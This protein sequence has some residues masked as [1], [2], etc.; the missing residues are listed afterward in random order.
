MRGATLLRISLRLFSL[1]ACLILCFLLLI[2]CNELC[3]LSVP[4]HVHRS[5]RAVTV[6]GDDDLGNVAFLVARLGIV[7][8]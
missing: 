2:K 7:Y 8:R 1:F 4:A 3:K 5:G 6:L